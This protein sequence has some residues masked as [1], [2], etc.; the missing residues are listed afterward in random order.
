[1]FTNTITLLHFVRQLFLPSCSVWQ[2][3]TDWDLQPV[4]LGTEIIMMLRLC[5]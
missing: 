4:G 5:C 1:L 3:F 2:S